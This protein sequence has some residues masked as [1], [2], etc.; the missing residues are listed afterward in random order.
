M[1]EEPQ[2]VLGLQDR[3]DQLIQFRFLHLARFHQR[4]EVVRVCLAGHVH[5]HAGANGLVSRVCRIAG[6]AVRH[7]AR[8]RKRIRDH[9]AL[10]V[11][12]LAQHV[13]SAATIA[14]GRHIVQVHVGAH[15][16]GRTRLGRSMERKQIDV[17]QQ[18]LRDIADES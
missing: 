6:I 16:R 14:A 18:H 7:Q 15:K 4:R 9:K 10:E 8:H 17:A 3:K 11:P 2:R 5:V 13:S 1:F 12:F